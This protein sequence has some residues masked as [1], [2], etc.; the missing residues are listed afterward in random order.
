MSQIEAILAKADP[1]LLLGCA[2]IIIATLI[3]GKREEG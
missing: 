2:T 3:Y 1:N